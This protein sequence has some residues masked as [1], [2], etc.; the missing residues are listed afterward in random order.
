MREITADADLLMVTVRG[1][2]RGIRPLVV[3]A[4]ARVDVVDDGLNPS[5]AL[6][7][8]AE[9][10]PSDRA[11][12]VGVAV[13]ARHQVEHHLV[14]QGVHRHLGGL[15]RDRVG[16]ARI[17]H[18]EICRDREAPGRRDDAGAD[19]AEGIQGLPLRDRRIEPDRFR[20]AQVVLA[21][22]MDA[23][24]QRHRR[25]SVR[26]ER[27]VV[28]GLDQHGTACSVIF[29]SRNVVFARDKPVSFDIASRSARSL[30]KCSAARRLARH[31]QGRDLPGR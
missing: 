12:I 22:G 9:E 24:Q 6:R 17:G 19:I 10:L 20:A 18:E 30:H 15:G 28:S 29:S 23:Q 11:Q 7:R 8:M 14:R 21:R 1:G 4:D 5:P 27:D 2:S 26:L 25:R 3:E 13:A 31:P 16:Q